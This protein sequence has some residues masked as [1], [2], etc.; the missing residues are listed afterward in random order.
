MSKAMWYGERAADCLA[1]AEIA[2][3][4]TRAG[5]TDMAARWIRPAELAEKWEAEEKT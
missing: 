2:P 4:A 1:L 5:Y 3:E